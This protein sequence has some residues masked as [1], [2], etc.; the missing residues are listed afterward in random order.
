MKKSGD[1]FS[2]SFVTVSATPST[3]ESSPDHAPS[4]L[5]TILPEGE[6]PPDDKTDNT[7]EHDRFIDIMEESSKP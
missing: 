2:A 4:N 3:S 1:Q 5:P 6:A 7:G